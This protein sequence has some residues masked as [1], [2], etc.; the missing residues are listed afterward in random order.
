MNT[1]TPTASHATQ[2]PV[3]DAR[4]GFARY[5]WLVLGLI[6]AMAVLYPLS[7]PV[8]VSVLGSMEVQVWR[9]NKPTDVTYTYYRGSIDQA[10][11]PFVIT[12]AYAPV[13]FICAASKRCD[14]GMRWWIQQWEVNIHPSRP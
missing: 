1:S 2:V 5:S 3:C 4:A 13:I 7:L 12:Q 10:K 9:P 11:S 8:A 14:R 6:L